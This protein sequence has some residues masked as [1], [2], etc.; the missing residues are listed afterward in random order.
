MASDDSRPA[1]G[2]RPRAFVGVRG[3][4]AEDYLQ[5]MVSNDVEV[6]GAGEACDAL[7][8][9]PKARVIAPLKVVRRGEEDFLLLTEPDLADVVRSH[10]LAFR[11]AA[12]LDVEVEEHESFLLL[13]GASPADGA[14][15][16]E[17]TDYGEVA[18]EVLDHAPP[19]DLPRVSEE[20]LERL[21]IEAGTP[22]FGREIDDR[23]LPAE[24]GLVERAVSLTKGC[25]P[26]QEPIARLHYR[27]HANRGLRVLRI[28]TES[29]LPPDAEIRLGDKVVGRVTSSARA[30]G[31]LVALAYVRV[32]VPPEAELAVGE[33]AAVPLD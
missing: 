28:E 17:T 6:L 23:V 9:T 33:S 11:F 29:P 32:E 25:Y 1:V 15:S 3:P 19:A 5:R 7:L 16:V 20:E 2:P 22:R 21:R 24:A 27:G 26:G 31:A 14:L 30:N 10:L 12:R 4:G 13:G 18:F 8:L